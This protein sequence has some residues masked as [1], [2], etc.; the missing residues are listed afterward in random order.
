MTTG[1]IFPPVRPSVGNTAILCHFLSFNN[2]LGYF[3]SFQVILSHFV[4]ICHFVIFSGVYKVEY[5]PPRWGGGIKSKGLEMGKKIKSLKKR[6]KKI[7]EDLTLLV[8]LKG[9]MQLL[10]YNLTPFKPKIYCFIALRG[11]KSK[12]L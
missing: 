3:K 4:S 6:K 5:S 12:I 11:R 1:L 2:I 10:Q 7:F 8:V 9:K